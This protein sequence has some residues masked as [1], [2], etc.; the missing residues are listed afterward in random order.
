MFLSKDDLRIHIGEVH[1]DKELEVQL[2]KIFPTGAK[3]KCGQCGQT[4]ETEYVKKEHILVEHPWKTL[5]ELV[6]NKNKKKNVEAAQLEDYNEKEGFYEDEAS[7]EEEMAEKANVKKSESGTERKRWYAGTEY[8]CNHCDRMHTSR[9]G[10]K[11]HLKK[12]HGFLPRDDLSSQFTSTSSLYTC[13]ICGQSFKREYVNINNHM[14]LNHKIS[15]AKYG[16]E[17][18]TKFDDNQISS[19]RKHRAL[20]SFVKLKK[21]KVEEEEDI[22]KEDIITKEK[23]KDSLNKEDTIVRESIEFSDSS[24]DE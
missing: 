6:S 15:L 23:S 20:N 3:D 13:K 14:R 9:E 12:M 19:K 18:E 21:L 7:D 17:Y 8:K 24:G 4:V 1:L 10:V 22:I 2:M 11:G 16:N 5:I